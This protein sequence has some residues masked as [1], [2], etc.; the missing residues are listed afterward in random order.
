MPS[1][2]GAYDAP[3]GLLVFVTIAATS[4]SVLLTPGAVTGT[5]V[6]RSVAL[7]VYVG[8]PDGTVVSDDLL[9]PA[10]PHAAAVTTIASPTTNVRRTGMRS[11]TGSFVGPSVSSP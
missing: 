1:T 3:V 9:D 5:L 4:I 10:F 6:S 8:P 2:S 7:A 11:P